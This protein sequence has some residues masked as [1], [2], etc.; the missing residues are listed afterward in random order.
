MEHIGHEV[1]VSPPQPGYFGA[2]QTGGKS[3]R[4][5]QIVGNFRHGGQIVG[6]GQGRCRLPVGAL[7]GLLRPLVTSRG[8][9]TH[10]ARNAAR[11]SAKPPENRAHLW[12][13]R[14]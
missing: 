2:A 11:R 8:G 5:S 4:Q 3:Q 12:P 6:F 13:L 1:N 9:G 7:V 10:G 14:R